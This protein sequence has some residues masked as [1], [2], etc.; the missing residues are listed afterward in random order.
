[1]TILLSLHSLSCWCCRD[2]RG[3][4][5]RGRRRRSLASH[6]WRHPPPPFQTLWCRSETGWGGWGPHLAGAA[7]GEAS[8]RQQQGDPEQSWVRERGAAW[9]CSSEGGGGPGAPEEGVWSKPVPGVKW[10]GQGP[11]SRRALHLCLG[12]IPATVTLPHGVLGP[13][14]VMSPPPPGTCLPTGPG[15]PE[16]VVPRGPAPTGRSGVSWLSA[17]F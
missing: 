15:G 16:V 4:R 6:I 8:H 9:P 2:G 7:S 13:L 11:G 3:A 12:C 10:E 14:E 17:V 1:M 5:S